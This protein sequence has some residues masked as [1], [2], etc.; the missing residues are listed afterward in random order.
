MNIHEYQAKE[1]FTAAGLPVPGGKVA[2]T[3]AQAVEL[4]NGYGLP[5]M[6]KCQVLTGGRGKAGGI[7]FCNTIEDVET[8]AGNILGMDIKGHTASNLLRPNTR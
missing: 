1:I 5:V 4:A 7:K 2:T 6:V 8:H 3:A